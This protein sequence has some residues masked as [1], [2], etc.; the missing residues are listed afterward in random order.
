MLAGTNGL[1]PFR[2]DRYG[3]LATTYTAPS[4]EA[5]NEDFFYYVTVK[6]DTDCFWL[7]QF[8]CPVSL[9]QDGGADELAQWSATFAKTP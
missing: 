1:T 8:V 4:D 9:A 2:Y 6:E 3:S 5:G 7:I